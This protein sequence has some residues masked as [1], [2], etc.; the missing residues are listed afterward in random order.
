VYVRLSR[1]H[2]L[3]GC[4]LNRKYS[5]YRIDSDVLDMNTQTTQMNV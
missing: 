5:I 4:T 1:L 3:F 2:E